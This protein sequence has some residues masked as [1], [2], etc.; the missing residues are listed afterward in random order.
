[1]LFI[2]RRYLLSKKSHSVVNIIAVVS[3]F[4]L[5]TPVAAVIVLL[6][7]FNGFGAMVTTMDHAVEGDLTLS[8]SEGKYFSDKEL[9]SVALRGVSGVESLSYVTELMLLAEH[10][11][12]NSL[13]TFRGVERDYTSTLPIEEHVYVGRFETELGD[14]DRVVIGNA[15]AT[16][17][18]VRSLSSVDITLYALKTGRLQSFIPMGRHA[19][20]SLRL[21]GVMML[22]Q[23]S[24]ELYGYTSRRVV[25]E[26]LGRED[27]LSKVIFKVSPEADI[28]RVRS[29]IEA[30]VGD[31]YFVKTRLELNPALYQII[32]SE[33]FGILLICTLVMI[34]ASFSLLGALAMLIIEKRGEVQTLRAMGTTR[35]DIRKIFR[36]EGVLLSATAIVLG[37]IVGITLTLLQ[38]NFGIVE[39]PTQS[40]LTSTYPVDLEW[41]DVVSVVAIAALI[42]QVVIR[43]VV[44]MMLKN[45]RL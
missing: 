28:E 6:S 11:E 4:S 32:H 38:Q 36:E 14:L 18:G 20:R 15:I 37:A 31:R 33:K 24:E 34:L 26:L 29:S 8:L 17:L 3:L 9:D 40:V 13:L 22:D 19:S 21:S 1:M 5:L 30:L 39:M 44:H 43:S 42:S 45:K 7:I 23:N 25:N 41:L 12:R 35:S 16:N 2:A 10:K 27:A